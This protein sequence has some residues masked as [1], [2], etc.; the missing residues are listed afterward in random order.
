M[1]NK[2][3]L[4]LISLNVLSFLL[5]F[6]ACNLENKS[7][8]T[9]N[10][11][12]GVGCLL[13][14][15]PKISKTAL[16]LPNDEL[17]IS[18]D[19]N[20]QKYIIDG[21]WEGTIVSPNGGGQIFYPG[22]TTETYTEFC[23]KS[24]GSVKWDGKDSN[25]NY[26]PS[27][28]YT[29]KGYTFDGLQNYYSLFPTGI[30]P[31]IYEVTVINN[32]SEQTDKIDITTSQTKITSNDSSISFDIKPSNPNLEWE[33]TLES[34]SYNKVLA[35]GKKGNDIVVFPEIVTLPLKESITAKVKYISNPSIS[36]SIIIEKTEEI[37]LTSTGTSADV[38]GLDL[39]QLSI[40]PSN[41]IEEWTL[42]IL[43]TGL[44]NTPTPTPTTSSNGLP[45]VPSSTPSPLF[46][47]TKTGKG[48]STQSLGS[49]INNLSAVGIYNF[50]V[51]YTKDSTINK[52]LSISVT[53]NTTDPSSPPPSG[54]PNGNGGGN[55]TPTPIT[56]T[57]TPSTDPSSSPSTDP[58]ATPT[59]TPENTATPTATPNSTPTPTATPQVCPKDSEW[60]ITED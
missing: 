2:K 15:L 17:T 48:E 50:K 14:D 21:I 36:K 9:K 29:I 13:Y 51:Y 24:F 22:N 39:L 10:N 42:E 12:P 56:I 35:T 46:K 16:V 4:K 6:Q 52:S 59:P 8:T 28:T 33:L 11:L 41:K 55:P 60:V 20:G 1:K 27:G 49:L 5:I 43:A 30:A 37:N 40:K 47:I 38:S 25:G 34:N 44:T 18:G 53:G 3:I 26:V 58:S 23:T 32:V 19:Y 54:D 45:S 57:P 7:F 31:I